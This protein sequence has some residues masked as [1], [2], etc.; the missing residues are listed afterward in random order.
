[1]TVSICLPLSQ[2]ASLDAMALW[3]IRGH[4]MATVALGLEGTSMLRLC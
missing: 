3:P 2:V 4:T 1:M